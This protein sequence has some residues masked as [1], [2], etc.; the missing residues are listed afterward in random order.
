MSNKINLNS[1]ELKSL[2]TY[3]HKN[4]QLLISKKLPAQ[5]VNIEGEAGTGKT[6]T[7]LQLAQELNLE[8]VRKNLA[9]FEDVSDYKK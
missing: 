7:I 1:E 9:E 5:T 2:L 4:N 3:I 8:L 6:S